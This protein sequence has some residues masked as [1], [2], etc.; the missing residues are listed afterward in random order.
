MN[1]DDSE[2]ICTL[3]KTRKVIISYNELFK[4]LTI[5]CR[6][7]LKK[8]STLHASDDFGNKAKQVL[9]LVTW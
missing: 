2:K 3:P 1:I 8:N 4:I 5:K 7:N 9:I 6:I